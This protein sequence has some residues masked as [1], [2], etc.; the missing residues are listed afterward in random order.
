[1]A[2]IT[3]KTGD[4]GYTSLGGISVRKDNEIIISLGKLDTLN[5]QCGITI[6]DLN[7]FRS[8]YCSALRI[9]YIVH[10]VDYID[11]IISKLYS[12]QQILYNI[13]S[14]I[15]FKY[16]EQT[17]SLLKKIS[18]LEYSFDEDL[19]NMEEYIEEN[20]NMLNLD[21]F[22]RYPANKTSSVFLLSRLIREL[23]VKCYDYGY[24]LI[25]TFNLGKYFNRCS[26]YYYL[27]AI[28]VNKKFNIE[29]D[30]INLAKFN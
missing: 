10:G 3:T 28:I 27:L 25:N 7:E 29:L 13:G 14:Y 15:H 16:C 21:Y 12:F 22:I 8:K 18:N 24:D 2:I 11:F 1:M 17:D 20:S 19:L 30:N 23:E 4:K 9:D 5:A 6:S 26:D